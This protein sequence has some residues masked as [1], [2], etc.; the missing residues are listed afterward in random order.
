[1]EKFLRR[2]FYEGFDGVLIAEPVA[3][4]DGVV[5]VF[6]E[7]IVGF[8]YAGG[9]AFRGD[10]VAPHGIDLGDDSDF[11]VGIEFGYSYGGAEASTTTSDQENVV[12]R[13]VHKDNPEL[14]G[15]LAK[16]EPAAAKQV[17]MYFLREE[18]SREGG[19]G[20]EFRSGRLG[21]PL[22]RLAR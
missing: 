12:G 1:L 19:A 18:K 22:V 6:V 8:D 15:R 14:S 17:A 10:G 2:F 4:G 21:T 5:G 3:A 20:A 7:R 16:R 9:A 11:E 13:N